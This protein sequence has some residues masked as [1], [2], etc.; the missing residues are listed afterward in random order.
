MKKIVL[1]CI[2]ASFV[3]LSESCNKSLSGGNTST[4]LS[5]GLAYFSFLNLATY[6]E[7]TVILLNTM[8]AT[9]TMLPDSYQATYIGFN[10]GTYAIE[11]QTVNDST[12]V[13]LPAA[14]YDSSHFYTVYLY[15]PTRDSLAAFV[16]YDDYSQVTQS[17]A[18]VR[19]I[20]ATPDAP[21]VD[22]YFG[23]TY[24][25]LDRTP[26][27]NVNSLIFNEFRPITIGNYSVIAKKAGTDSTIATLNGNNPIDFFGGN[28]YTIFLI[29]K[30]DSLSLQI[31]TEQL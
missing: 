27:D 4:G 30:T 11:F 1:S 8:A 3:F 18:Y 2:L 16:I 9:Q 28:A 20:N 31:L 26:A 19:F 7:P 29:G 6:S 5:T 22:V 25:Q 21:A 24:T 10:P 12:E 13:V 17:S 23:N 14:P 15:N